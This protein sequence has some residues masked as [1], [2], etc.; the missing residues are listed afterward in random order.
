MNINQVARI[1]SLIGEPAR[2]AMLLQ[3]M[4]GRSMSA[5]ELARTAG[6]TAATA[7]RH[8]ALLVEAELL[9]VTTLG[10]HRYHR[11]ASGQ[12]ATLL[13]SL[14]QIATSGGAKFRTVTAGPKD[15]SL[16]KARTCY[17]HL[18]GRLGVAIARRL[19]EDRA[20]VLEADVAWVTEQAEASL[21]KIGIVLP[22]GTEK[23]PSSTR[24]LCRPCMDWS[25]HRFHV[26]GR[27]GAIVCTHCLSRG[28]VARRPDSRSLE[29]PPPGQ[30]ALRNWLGLELWNFVTG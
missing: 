2:T 15:E 30:A 21:R 24:P 26:A 10:R 18:A 5:T 9:Q 3:L 16:R 6:V 23:E 19:A 22:D 1:A 20:V 27:L 7:S 28:W 14:M 25:E 29:I 13:E 8:L 12:V 17:D 11:I 4:D